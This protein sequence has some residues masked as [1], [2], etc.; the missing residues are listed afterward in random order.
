MSLLIT[1]PPIFDMGRGF[2]ECESDLFISENF[3]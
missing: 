2:K 3:E 1:F